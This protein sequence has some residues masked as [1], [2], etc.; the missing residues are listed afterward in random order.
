[1]RKIYDKK[2]SIEIEKLIRKQRW[3]KEKTEIDEPLKNHN[4]ENGDRIV[5]AKSSV[6]KTPSNTKVYKSL[7]R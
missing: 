5:T 6:K 1:M 7:K 4:K 2:L 3:K